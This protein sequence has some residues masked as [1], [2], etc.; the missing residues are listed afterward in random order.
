M[1]KKIKFDNVVT[2]I[3]DN[4]YF[5]LS[6]ER[7][8]D[9][10]LG[11]DNYPKFLV[12]VHDGRKTP[13]SNEQFFCY[14][15]RECGIVHENGLDILRLWCDPVNVEKDLKTM[16]LTLIFN[17]GEGLVEFGRD[18]AILD[19]DGNNSGTVYGPIFEEYYIG[20]DEPLDKKIVNKMY[21]SFMRATDPD[22]VVTSN[23][24]YDLRKTIDNEF[25]E[26]INRIES[27][28]FE[29]SERLFTKKSKQTIDN[30]NDDKYASFYYRE[31]G[32][33]GPAFEEVTSN[34]FNDLCLSKVS[35]SYVGFSLYSGK[36]KSVNVVLYKANKGDR[37]ACLTTVTEYSDKN[38]LIKVSE[39]FVEGVRVDK[40]MTETNKKINT[41]Y[42]DMYLIMI[43]S[44]NLTDE[45]SSITLRVVRRGLFGM[46]REVYIE[47][48]DINCS[49]RKIALPR[50]Q[51][52]TF[53]SDLEKFV[54]VT[55]VNNPFVA[56]IG[57][58]WGWYQR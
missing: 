19:E 47:S 41:K 43:G 11:R 39:Y 22:T 13:A 28:S 45:I 50:G 30:E 23:S 57:K 3:S 14:S 54:T 33:L 15:S 20:N 1:R 34:E 32:D 5:V 16:N 35:L 42:K 56:K 10:K 18:C 29:C 2:V 38:E 9:G 55:Y 31:D 27:A 25:N 37:P 52:E 58:R 51:M 4:R 49:T 46:K 40:I 26:D 8:E 12:T 24:L 48:E 44:G 36:N 21:A 6:R 17:R 7:T 53:L